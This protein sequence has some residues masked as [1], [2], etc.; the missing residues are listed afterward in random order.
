LKAVA[1]GRAVAQRSTGRP[2]GARR[3]DRTRRL[4]GQLFR[5]DWARATRVF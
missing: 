4:D 2:A 5:P 1:Y 3:S